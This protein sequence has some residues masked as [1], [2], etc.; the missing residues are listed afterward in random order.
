MIFSKSKNEQPTF[1]PFKIQE[2]N[3]RHGK[4]NDVYRLSWTEASLFTGQKT[5]ES[6]GKSFDLERLR[7]YGL[8]FVVLFLFLIGRTAWL[9]V[10][11]GDYY[12][13]MAEGNRIR[14]E[15]IEAR[16]GV[17]YDRNNVPLVHNQANFV[18]YLVPSDLTKNADD[19]NK[20]VM[21]IAD[22]LAPMSARQNLINSTS[23]DEQ[24]TSKE[25]ARNIF[26]GLDNVKP[27]SLESFR[28]LFVADGIDYDKAILLYLESAN[29]RGVVISNKIKRD[30][31]VESKTLSHV[32]GYTGKINDKELAKLG[33]EYLPIDYIGKNGLEYFYENQLRGQ[34]GKKQIEVDALGKEKKIL[35]FTESVDGNSLVLTIDLQMQKKLEEL[36]L[37]QLQKTGL[38]RA[39]AIILNPNNGEVLSMVS[40]P[41]YDNNL[42]ARGITHNEY[43]K[44]IDDK[45][46]P[47]FNRAVA[48]EFPCGST[49][50]PVMSA[51]ALQEGVIN[52]STIF[53]SRGGLRVGQWFFPDWKAGG[54]GVTNVKKAIAESVNTFFYIIG[55]GYEDFQGL[56][57]DRIIKYDKLFGLGEQVGIDLP[58]EANGFVP[59]KQWK[60]E[61]KHENW[62]VGDTYH[63]SIGQG[64]LTTTPLQVAQFTEYFANGG[65]MYV[66]HL[67][68]TILSAD[69]K[70]SQ[71][72]EPSITKE[73]IV[74]PVNTQIVREGMRQTVTNG[75][76]RSMNLV[77]PVAVAGKT[78]T[79]QWST[80]KKPHAWFTGFAP[81]E[82]PELVITVLIE[83]GEGGDINA[84]P[85][86]REFLKWYF[87]PKVASSTA[88]ST[89]S[90]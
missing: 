85:I 46:L 10:I 69:E 19:L 11:N 84:V 81:Y 87:S 88:T 6:V 45:N 89:P 61:A 90:R 60:E 4:L 80:K 70:S 50:K 86:A 35:N 12:Y 56:G 71:K 20:M 40:Y 53:T 76:A 62:Y 36:V 15:R 72:V 1:D 75:S 34:N 63:L 14:V 2:G 52:E 49:I 3:S 47:L 73:N 65:K 33:D 58:G 48:G 79:A 83:E 67:V 16:R 51:A 55:G 39:S 30:Y 42:F 82:K 44:I 25:I 24:I 26:A 38:T 13:K 43:Q 22:V 54:H 5:G 68:K 41:A 77:V 28:P 32:L 7:V 21:R 57:V 8:V 31:N 23:T 18:L 17:I 74:D 37:A 9:Q 64:D 29:W 78:G 27:H 59:T 66:P